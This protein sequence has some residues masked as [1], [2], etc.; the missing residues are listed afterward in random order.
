MGERRAL[1]ELRPAAAPRLP[2]FA[3]AA[4]RRY[5]WVR[6]WLIWNEPNKRLWLRPTR[7][8]I[9]VQHLLNPGTRGSM[10]CCRTPGSAAA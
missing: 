1:A 3:T 6:Y 9:Y 7:P 4:A 5:P 10:P 2:P 8:T